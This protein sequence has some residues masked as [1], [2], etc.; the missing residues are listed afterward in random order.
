MLF[1]LFLLVYN[2]G[3]VLYLHIMAQ[4]GP[5]MPPIFSNTR[6]FFGVT[7]EDLVPEQALKVQEAAETRWQPPRK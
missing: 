3:P 5:H 7:G 6:S 4:T 2:T 1:H